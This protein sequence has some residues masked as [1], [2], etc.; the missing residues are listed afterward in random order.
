MLAPLH[1]RIDDYDVTIVQNPDISHW[2]HDVAIRY[3]AYVTIDEKTMIYEFYIP[4]KSAISI[5]RKD[6]PIEMMILEKV[7]HVIEEGL[8]EHPHY[9]RYVFSK[10]G[11]VSIITSIH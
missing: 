10:I 6:A 3:H 2:E 4:H 8:F 11:F 9:Q 7:K 1:F 5:S